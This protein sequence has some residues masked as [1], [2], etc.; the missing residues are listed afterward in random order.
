MAFDS[1]TVLAL[2]RTSG[3]APETAMDSQYSRSARQDASLSDVDSR[4]GRFSIRAKLGQGGMGVV[5]LGYDAQLNRLTAIKLLCADRARPGGH[6]RMLRE[7]RALASVSHPNVVQVYEVGEH[8]SNIYIAMEFVDG[9]TLR[10][11]FESRPRDPLEVCAHRLV[12]AGR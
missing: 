10:E 3:A 2:D 4:I 1:E 12:V 11:W 8:G 7:A 9:P 5:Y 6:A